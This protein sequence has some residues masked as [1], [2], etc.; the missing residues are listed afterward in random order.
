MKKK[1]LFIGSL[2]TKKVHF[3][4]E[5]NKTGDIYKI[6]K[7]T[8][9]FKISTINLTEFKLIRTIKMIFLSMIKKYDCIFIS[10]CITG[11]SLS[12][13]LILKY[14]KKANKNNIYVYWIGNGTNGLNI[15]NKHMQSLKKVKCVILES[16]QV[17][18]ENKALGLENTVIL[19]CVKPNYDL[20][21]SSKDYSKER[22]LKCIYFSRICEE[23]GLMDAIV[24]IEKANQELGKKAF[25]LDIAGSPTSEKAFAFEKVMVE[26]IKGKDEFTYYGKNFCI[27]GIS[28]YERLQQYDLHLFPSKFLQECVPGSIVDMFIAGVPTLASTFPNVKNILNGDNAFFFKQ[29]DVE[30]L[31]KQLVYIYKHTELLPQKRIAAFKEQ[32][33]YNETN[34]LNL[35]KQIGII[36][37]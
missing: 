15:N 2:P 17:K 33:K 30:D 35:S 28:S 11:G 5:T 23:K 3:N 18:E 4:G 13:H 21:V 25:T 34:F 12:A 9:L 19:P 22:T 14:A 37:Q 8:G 7:K 32:S 1:M 6:F 29:N 16:E 24:A 10:K 31:I 20:E 26:Y 27:N 36:E